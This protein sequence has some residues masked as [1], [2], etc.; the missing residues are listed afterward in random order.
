MY[1][2]DLREKITHLDSDLLCLLE[3]RRQLSLEVAY[4]KKDTKKHLRDQVREKKL[5]ESLIQQAAKKG[6][7]SHYIISVYT[8]IIED[9]V[10]LQKDIFQSELQKKNNE[11]LGDIYEN[12]TIAI[13]GGI[14]SYSYIAA[15]RFFSN[16]P[17]LKQSISSM[18]ENDFIAPLQSID[19]NDFK[20]ILLNVEEEKADF[21]II[22]IENSTSGGI[23]GVYDLLLASP[24]FIV[25]EQKQPINHCLV[26][27]NAILIE[28]IVKIVAHPE[29]ALQCNESLQKK[30][31]AKIHQ[32]ASTSHAI[33]EIL[34]HPNEPIAAIAS[35]EAATYFGLSVILKDMA[36]QE[37]NTTRFLIL[38]KKAIDVSLSVK[39]KISLVLSTNQ[40]AGA[41]ADI[42]TLFKKA[43]IPLTKLESRP[44]PHKPW[45]QLFYVDLEANIAESHV[46]ECIDLLSKN[47]VFYRLLGCYPAQENNATSVSGQSLVHAITSRLN[48]SSQK[49]LSHFK[50]NNSSR[51]QKIMV[52]QHLIGGEKMTMIMGPPYVE[53]KKQIQFLAK[54]AHDTGADLLR[55]QCF[56]M[57]LQK[58]SSMLEA[59]GV[60]YLYQ[61]ANNYHLPIVVEIGDPHLVPIMAK[62]IAV[63]EIG[64]Q[65]MHNMALLAAVG[66]VNCPV[67]LNRGFLSSIDEWLA[68]ANYIAKQ[69][70]QQI[71]L[72]ENAKAEMNGHFISSPSKSMENPRIHS[73]KMIDLCLIAQLKTQTH[74]PILIN[75]SGIS[76]ENE[77]LLSLIKASKSLQVNGIIIDFFSFDET[78]KQKNK[79]K[80]QEDFILLMNQIHSI[81]D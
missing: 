32:V 51:Y 67:I 27:L 78:N 25:G 28:K 12:K 54:Q 80:Y 50:K 69:G 35:E 14:G 17:H 29:A 58:N 49:A 21:G 11:L 68:S 57:N 5:L 15:Q 34:A 9:S 13:L 61:A 56:N 33:Q 70:N 44:I 20:R 77:V 3:K 64:S 62:K 48:P 53:S 71:I 39:S 4:S 81:I 59:K 16:H 26:S 18:T 22:P 74:W 73:K 72:C 38:S 66:K 31:S 1:L 55:S 41:L 46:R 43:N 75:L 23:T 63:L 79:F 36:D 42:L 6:L 45:Q 37:K 40:Q 76:S 30:T 60:D 2:H 52:D 7:D 10:Q 19:C 47:C 24:L 65:N 8:L